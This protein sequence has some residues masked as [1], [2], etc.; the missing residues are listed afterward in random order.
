MQVQKVLE[1]QRGFRFAFDFWPQSLTV[2]LKVDKILKDFDVKDYL[3]ALRAIN[4]EPVAGTVAGWH[5]SQSLGAPFVYLGA[6]EQGD[7][8]TLP[9]IELETE[10]INRIEVDILPWQQKTIPK[11]GLCRE[12]FATGVTEVAGGRKLATTSRRSWK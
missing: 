5:N 8:I 6:A 2:T 1:S 9:K 11:E 12:I 7:S 10:Y 4:G 3:V